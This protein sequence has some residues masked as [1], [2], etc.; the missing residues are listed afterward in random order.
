MP[1]YLLLIGWLLTV[2][3]VSVS[4]GDVVRAD[5]SHWFADYR[6]CPLSLQV[7]G[8]QDLQAARGL[9]GGELRVFWKQATAGMPGSEGLDETAITVI[10]GA[11]TDTIVRQVP[12]TATDVILD[13]VPRGRDLEIVHGSDPA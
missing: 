5:S 2:V 8:P 9:K 11:G 12:P 10:V 7:Q 1:R 6:L 13:S 3:L 4:S